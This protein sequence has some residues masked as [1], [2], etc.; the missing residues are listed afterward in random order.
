MH[1]FIDTNIL[2]NFFHFSDDDLGNL[3]RV[4]SAHEH[5]SAHILLTD[6]VR[7]EFKRNREFR[8][9]DA[10]RRFNDTGSAAQLPY[11]MK[12]YCEYE[13]ITNL[14]AELERKQVEMMKWANSEIQNETLAADRMIKGIFKRF[15]A[16]ETTDAI[17]TEAWMRVTKG[18][19]PGKDH[20]IGDAINWV[21]LLRLVPDKDDLHV[22]SG[23][24]DYYSVLD[25][26]SAHPFLREEWSRKKSSAL[27]VYRTLSEF[28]RLHVEEIEFS[29]DKENEEKEKEELIDDLQ[30][31]HSFA[32]THQVVRKLESY[33]YFSLKEVNRILQAVLENDQIHQIVT[34][35]DVS[36]FLNRIAVPRMRDIKD[37]EYRRILRA[38]IPS[39][40]DRPGSAQ[41]G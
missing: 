38:V 20:S 11:F 27:H 9:K 15:P 7:D 19:P 41:Q 34:D 17:F 22:V 29:F 16:K 5:G 39:L 21:I 25:K 13:K 33:H 40:R 32:M 2:L 10:L 30:S 4:F 12:E 8:I 28:T 37:E 3:E 23:D 31:S 35:W 14:Y 6:Q 24:G 1:V 36:D 26:K 18:N